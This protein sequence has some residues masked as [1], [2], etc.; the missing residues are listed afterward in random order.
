VLNS[1]RLFAVIV[2]VIAANLIIGAR[3]KTGR[4]LPSG[5]TLPDTWPPNIEKLTLDPMPVPYL[6]SPPKVI[7]IDTGR[8]LF[9]DDFLIEKT[10]LQRVF[11]K[12][13]YHEKNPVLKPDRPWESEGGR[14]NPCAMPFSD[15]V[16]YDPADRLF[17]MWYMGGYIYHTCL[18]TSKDGIN[19]DKPQLDVRPGTNIVLPGLNVEYNNEQKNVYRDSST[20]WLDLEETNPWKRYKM[21]VRTPV[22]R[23]GALEIFYSSDGIHW[24]PV[25]RTGLCGDRSTIFYNPFRK[26][27]VYSLRDYWEPK[28]E[29]KLRKFRRY[30]EGLD[31]VTASDNWKVRTDVGLWF[32]PDRND[33]PIP[34]S[35]YQPGIYNFDGV[36]YESLM[37]GLYSIYRTGPKDGRPKINEILLGFSRDGFHFHR[38]SYETFIPVGEK[39]GVWN[40]GNVQSAGGCCLIVG[41]KLYFYVSGRAGGSGDDTNG[42]CSTGLAVLRRDG[43]ASMQAGDTEGTLTTRPVRFKGSYLRVN[44]DTTSGQLQVELLD[45]SREVIPPFSRA[46]CVT[47]RADST[48]TAVK[49]K[50]VDDLSVLSGKIVRFRFYLQNGDLYAFWV[51]PDTSGAS[52]GYVAA[53]GPGF[54]G[55]TDTVGGP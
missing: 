12:A 47:V 49:W 27:W 51:S 16:W 19:W 41:D 14:G 28:I 32:A 9:V 1:K 2:V 23:H 30:R 20:V 15:G 52:Y 7:T 34:G 50:G 45:E 33:P 22:K 53:G 21:V 8:Q 40:Y 26:V 29:G 10:N 55:P 3:Q 11:H 24:Y 6:Q 4:T 38:P 31:L 46:N 35:D 37:L 48:S 36:A 25:G 42:L 44:A 39:K 54:T 43:F 13:K 5:I 17:K 18:A